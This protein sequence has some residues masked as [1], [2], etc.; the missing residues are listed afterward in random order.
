LLNPTGGTPPACA[1]RTISP[2]GRRGYYLTRTTCLERDGFV[3]DALPRVPLVT[4]AI[5]ERTVAPHGVREILTTR[6]LCR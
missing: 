1:R 3:P 5:V 2:F 6:T 4:P